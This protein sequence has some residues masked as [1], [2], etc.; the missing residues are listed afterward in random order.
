MA[1][2]NIPL[3]NK[4]GTKI[5]STMYHANGAP[6]IYADDI[7]WGGAYLGVE[8]NKIKDINSTKDLLDYI[9]TLA[10][11]DSVQDGIRVANALIYKGIISKIEDFNNIA[12]FEIGDTYVISGNVTINNQTL[13]PGDMMIC[14]SVTTGSDNKK[15]AT[16]NYVQTNVVQR[17]ITFGNTSASLQFN[18]SKNINIKTGEGLTATLS[19]TTED[20]DT[21]T[22]S[23][24]TQSLSDPAALTTEEIYK[25]KYDKFGH[26]VSLNKWTPNK[27]T[28]NDISYNPISTDL[29]IEF[30]GKGNVTI[31][32]GDD[33]PL[34]G[35]SKNSNK[36]TTQNITNTQD[37]YYKIESDSDGNLVV[38][39]PWS[40]VQTLAS[41]V[42]GSTLG[43][44]NKGVYWTGSAFSPC[45]YEVNATVPSDAKFTDTTYT[46]GD[47]LDLTSGKFSVIAAKTDKLG[48][49]LVNSVSTTEFSKLTGKNYAINIDSNG[50]AYV[51]VPWDNT[52]TWRPINAYSSSQVKTAILNNTSTSTQTLNFSKEFYYHDTDAT[53]ENSGEL[54]ITWAEV[55]SNG[56]VVYTY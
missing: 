13:E 55:S 54:H 35:I 31:N 2:L 28:V 56:T 29:S 44:A 3:S 26:I 4:V 1:H 24:S 22:V 12:E 30:D 51:N 49:I 33:I 7:D 42:G 9:D 25:F 34:F 43:S 46:A 17:N 36:I 40:D 18:N 21:L 38:N 14:Q 37:R 48:G 41:L 15:I 39:V 27:V 53:D 11:K 52:N 8:N 19:K 16:W 20:N 23:H 45:T 50:L 6:S 10:T 32:N 5:A 47:G